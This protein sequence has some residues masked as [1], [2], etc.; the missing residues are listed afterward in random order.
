MKH[1]THT[2]V[3]TLLLLCLLPEILSAQQQ[4]LPVDGRDFYIGLVMPSFY[5]DPPQLSDGDFH[6]FSGWFVLVSSYT[7]NNVLLSYF[8]PDGTETTSSSYSISA[9]QGTAIALSRAFM[10]MSDTAGDVPEF[11]ACHI[12][13]KRPINVQFFS[14][15]A[16]SGGSYLAIPTPA[17][18]KSYVIPTY[19]D[20]PGIGAGQSYQAE[21]AGGF[22][23]IVAAFDG[24]T[25]TITPNGL[26]AGGHPGVNSGKGATGKKVPYT[27]SLRRG[28]CYWV[29]GDGS[30]A[31][32][33][34]SGSTVTSDKPIAV[35]AGHEDA[36]IGEAPSNGLLDGRDF[37]IE[38]VIPAEYWDNTGYVSIPMAPA[39]PT[40]ETRAG[41]GQNYRVFTDDPGG[42]NVEENDCVIAKYSLATS[43]FAFPTPQR[44]GIGCPVEMHS[45][46]GHKFGVMCYEQRD[47]GTSS[48][49]PSESMMS[50]V[51]MSRWRNSYLFY[52][53]TNTFGE[54]LQDYYISVIGEINDMNT[55][56]V[57]S[58]NGGALSKLTSL[59]NQGT[60]ATI[61]NHPEL[62]GVRYRVHPGSYYITNPRTKIDPKVDI[63]TL[64]QGSFMVYHYGMRALDPDFDLG[65]FCG[66]DFFFSYALP[67]GMTV[68]SGGGNPVVKVD[69]F[70]SS[71]HVCVHDSIPLASATL[72]DDPTGDVYGRPGKVSHNAIFD[73]TSDPNQTREIVFNGSDT[74]VCF[75]ILVSN[76]FD[77]AYAPLYIVDKNGFHLSPILELRYKA[78]AVKEL[79]YSPGAKPSPYVPVDTLLF[80]L[81]RVGDEACSTLVFINTAAKG[82]GSFSIS[83][84]SIK[85]CDC[86]GTPHFKISSTIPALPTKLKGGDTL[87][88]NVCF[89]ATDTLQYSD[90]VI[91]KTDCF[92]APLLAI[93][94]G[95]TP[96]IY[97][98][99]WDF[100]E[101]TVG[102]TK[103]HDI[104]VIN[105]GNMPF[106]LTKNWLLHNSTVFSMD[107]SSAALLPAVLGPGKSITLSMCYTPKAPG[108]EDSTS[109]DWNTDIEKQGG[110]DT[111]IKSW[112]FLKGKPV[113]PGLIWD[114]PSQLDSVICED[115]V[116]VHLFLYNRTNDKAQG[117]QVFLTG[118]DTA[119]YSI[120]RNSLGYR[121][122]SNFAINYGDSIWVD[123]L[124]KADLTKTGAAKYAPRHMNLVAT[125]Q[126]DATNLN[127][128]TIVNFTDLVLHAVLTLSQPFF[129]YGFLTKGVPEAG[130]IIAVDTGAPFVVKSV[131]F[132]TPPVDSISVNGKILSPG[133]TIGRGD[134]ITLH[135]DVHLDTYTDT[136][137]SYTIYSDHECG[138]VT[139][140][141]HLAASNL[142]VQAT[143]Y[144]APKVYINCR[145]HDS[146]VI[147]VNKG[148]VSIT[149]DSVDISGES[150]LGQFDL[151]DSK[152]TIGTSITINKKLSTSQG[153]TI[154][155]IYHPTVTGSASGTI[156]FIYDSAGTKKVVTTTATGTGAALRNTLSAAPSNLQPYTANTAANFPVSISLR[157]T[158]LPSSADARRLTFRLTY[159]RDVVDF[160]SVAPANGKYFWT[161]GTPPGTNDPGGTLEYIDFDLS[162]NTLFTS[163][164]DIVT[165]QYRAMVA[166][167]LA[168][169]FTVS[170][171]QFY[172]SKNNPICYI[173]TD[174]IPGEFMP[175]YACGDTT[176][177]KY[178]LGVLP[179]RIA[180]LS[181]SVPKETETPVLYYS[182]NNPDIPIKIELYNVLGELVRTIK[183]AGPQAI[184]D[185][186]I[187]VGT[188][189]LTSGN[190]IV[191]LTTTVSS[192]SASFILQK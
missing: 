93:G 116:V 109:V 165:I 132:P 7:D 175:I 134:T 75:D 5:S 137:V 76:P 126:D 136:T 99:D 121:P 98:T 181:P 180:K 104:T 118:P 144:P 59:A 103:C 110:F 23:Q 18:G 30:D 52:V 29:K 2:I 48:P 112:S 86:Q 155:I 58:H 120:I 53:P 26:T 21:N 72:I 100:H 135:I 69:T 42:A 33:D 119:E 25:V 83:D 1:L 111:L 123:V 141:L 162:S 114:R 129:D 71:W 164:E 122:L 51:P 94:K 160:S 38:Q 56:I 11:R 139:G 77:T 108:P 41:Y 153:D 148:S 68:S 115:S 15:G 163:L 35:L 10:Q 143:D 47:Q 105:K 189:N 186:M 9:K 40:D 4:G 43:P 60:F 161:K 65:D 174:T 172:D 57:Y 171:V 78:P 66:D 113:K 63:D 92:N 12:T 107:P 70:C 16:C 106:T 188:L 28:Q 84:A 130:N 89:D 178:L 138:D 19:F 173:T 183:P 125:W 91:I 37:M 154:K 170:N 44:T 34:L 184:G 169:A 168:T 166:K 167:D 127:D 145:E 187:P 190:Y 97:A 55:N 14:T 157:D 85:T 159:M 3:F 152:G 192:Q 87:Q 36:F 31:D 73:L 96:L 124:F 80:P 191:R 95:G 158:A 27:V 6:G 156:R 17:L 39:S 179:T 46:D 177:H 150:P 64:L 176:L 140:T 20:N 128:S 54:T 88:V 67:I 81:T 102:L 133:D 142:S 22:F 146:T 90:S 117:V 182:V 131:S 49:F 74:S 62:K 82:T 147:F 185:Y 45:L 149:L 8:N 32:N 61:P 13:A 151:V 79:L 24:T 101:V 50:I